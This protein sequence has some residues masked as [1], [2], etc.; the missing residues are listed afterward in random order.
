LPDVTV[1][2]ITMTNLHEVASALFYTPDVTGCEIF[3]TPYTIIAMHHLIAR[4][5]S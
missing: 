2:Y 3:P 1:Q 5:S 4:D